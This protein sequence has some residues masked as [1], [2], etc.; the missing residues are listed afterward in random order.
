MSQT[1]AIDRPQEPETGWSNVLTAVKQHAGTTPQP[2]G[3][4]VIPLFGP[5]DVTVLVVDQS[6]VIRRV[7]SHG[8]DALGLEPADC[9]GGP[10]LEL[11]HEA[12]RPYVTGW[13]A[14][15]IT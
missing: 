14:M 8:R 15:M 11:V 4:T 10:A 13:F 6:G 7:S 2:H 1:H 9:E 12:D 5:L 3:A